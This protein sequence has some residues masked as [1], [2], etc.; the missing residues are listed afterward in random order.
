MIDEVCPLYEK[1][2]NILENSLSENNSDLS[3]LS[4][5]MLFP[6]INEYFTP[7]FSIIL[8]YPF[9]CICNGVILFWLLSIKL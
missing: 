9:I 1:E 8:I 3:I 2:F 5:L 6:K 4:A 7:S